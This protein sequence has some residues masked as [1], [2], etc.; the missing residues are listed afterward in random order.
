M[1]FAQ[2]FITAHFTETCL[3]KVLVYKKKLILILFLNSKRKKINFNKNVT[4]I[5]IILNKS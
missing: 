4:F 5:L 1:N 3:K 2:L